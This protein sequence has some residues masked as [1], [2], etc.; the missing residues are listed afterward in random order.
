VRAQASWAHPTPATCT[1][2]L[3]ARLAPAPVGA[4]L[5]CFVLRSHNCYCSTHTVAADDAA[6]AA[7]AAAAAAAAV[8]GQ[9]PIRSQ[10]HKEGGGEG[11]VPG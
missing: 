11:A 5:A 2:V 3:E 8:G 9:P 10:T 6:V 1:R 4:E 7:A